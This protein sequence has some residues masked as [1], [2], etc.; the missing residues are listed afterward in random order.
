MGYT[1]YNRSLYRTGFRPY[2]QNNPWAASQLNG[3]SI[4]E[5]TLGQV[6][7]FGPWVLHGEDGAGLGQSHPFT[8]SGGWGLH[9]LGDMV[10]DQSQV[11]YRGL[12]TTTATMNSNNV[13]AAV[14]AQLAADGLRVTNVQSDADVL[15]R[16]IGGG[17]TF[18]ATLT[19]Q[20]NNG[21]GFGQPQ[22]IASI[23]DHEVY[24]ATGTM[25]ISSAITNVRGP[26][27]GGGLPDPA[28]TDL[29]VWLENN[30]LWIALGI[31]AA[32]TLPELVKRI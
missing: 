9:G 26:G 5:A 8:E 4:A 32:I 14:T 12:W 22:D 20:V 21:M 25:P 30:A 31:A 10:A 18:N 1:T 27:A 13:L 15:T 28:S 11:T 19:I 7:P 24:V 29:S 3:M 23:V 2:G 17:R 6:H 16:S